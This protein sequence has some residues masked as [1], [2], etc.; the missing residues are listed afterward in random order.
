MMLTGALRLGGQ[1]VR[2][3]AKPSLGWKADD[4]HRGIAIVTRQGRIIIRP[5]RPSPA[6]PLGALL[7]ALMRRMK[8]RGE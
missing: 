2:G 7:S 3:E 8:I 4:A 1:H 5:C 6:V